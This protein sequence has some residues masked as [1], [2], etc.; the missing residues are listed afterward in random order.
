MF[1]FLWFVFYN[2]AFGAAVWF[3]FVEGVE[4]A[5]H[6]AKFIVWALMFPLAIFMFLGM[7]GA[8][9]SIRKDRAASG[10]NSSY[11]V[12]RLVAGLVNAAAAGLLVW[13]GHFMTALVVV[14]WILAAECLFRAAA[15]PASAQQAT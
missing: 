12:R 1:R 3:G 13:N 5:Q 8:I 7:Q 9:E 4:G 6:L 11:P 2:T 10:R 14:A 15:K